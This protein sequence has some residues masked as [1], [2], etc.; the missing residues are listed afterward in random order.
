MIDITTATTAELVAFWNEHAPQFG[1]RPVN[2][3]ATRADAERRVQELIDN[4]AAHE[5]DHD[6][7]EPSPPDDEEELSPPE[8]AQPVHSEARSAGI[9]KSWQ[10]PETRAKR[11]QRNGVRVDGE[12]YRSVPAAFRALDLPMKD[13][14]AF[15][16]QLK[17]DKTLDA[18]DHHWEI[19]D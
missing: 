14:V 11:I 2:R 7:F 10:N 8:E 17:A 18:Y 3:F 12:H 13:L 16:M 19:T 9:A 5:E 15:R 1:V 6:S 4:I